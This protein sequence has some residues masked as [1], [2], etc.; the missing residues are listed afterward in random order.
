MFS[1]VWLADGPLFAH[2]LGQVRTHHAVLSACDVGR[3]RVRPG[4]EPLGLTMAL[5]T[6]GVQSVLAPVCPIR[7]DLAAEAMVRY[8]RGLAQGLSAARALVGVREQIPDMGALTLYGA[9]W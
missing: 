4:H 5:V 3:S 9:D 8:H 7:E 2:E 1:S 6:V